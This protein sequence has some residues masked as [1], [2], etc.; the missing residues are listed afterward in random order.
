MSRTGL[1]LIDSGTSYDFAVGIDGDGKQL[2]SIEPKPWEPGDSAQ[3]FRV[4]L[5]PWDEGIASNRIDYDVTFNGK[6][7]QRPSRTY[8][9]ANADLSWPGIMV[10][11]PALGSIT[12]SGQ[13]SSFFYSTPAQ[14]SYV[15]VPDGTIHPGPTSG[16]GYVATPHASIHPTAGPYYA[17]VTGG[18]PIYKVI[19]S[20]NGHIYL[21]GGQFVY[22]VDRDYTA[23]LVKDFGTGKQVYDMEPFNNELIFAMGESVK[24][25][26]MDTAE[27]FTQ[28]SD[29]TFAIALGRVG[30]FLWR[31]ESVNKISNCTTTP[32]TLSN[33]TPAS[34]NQYS[35][36]D[37]TF[38]ITDIVEFA[39][40]PAILKPDGVYFPDANTDF[41]NQTP[42]L[43]YDSHPDNGKGAFTAW[44]YLW[45]PSAVGL[46]RVT[47]GESIPFGP[48]LTGMPNYRFWVRGGVEWAGDIYLLCNDQ[49]GLSNTSVFKMQAK[50]D[51]VVFHQ[52]VQESSTTL[53]Y[54][55][56][57]SS[58][59][60]LPSVLF[61]F[62]SAVS[63]FKLGRGGG[64]HID[65]PLYEWGTAL[66]WQSGDFVLGPDLALE[67]YLMG[68]SVVSD[69]DSSES[70]TCSYEIDRSGSFTSLLDTQDGSGTAPITNTSGFAV[71][72]RYATVSDKGQ[73]F[74]LKLEGT[75]DSGLGSDRLEVREVW[76]Y[77]FCHP[78][79]VDTFIVGIY[80][81]RQAKVR[82]IKQGRTSGETL[83]LFRKWQKDGTI[84]TC[85]LNDYEESRTIRVRVVGSKKDPVQTV[86]KA[87]ADEDNTDVVSVILR[88]TDFANT[89]AES[90]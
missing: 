63:Y 24:I 61:G 5:H 8:I 51:R 49:A 1:K 67:A 52:L 9:K 7:V 16:V 83:R 70:L 82:G 80:A 46:L 71:N 87:G 12:L 50:G 19:R 10:P 37:T 77:G 25:W 30:E 3:E 90:L 89:Y 13:G 72:H 53:G 85:Q 27:T 35:A 23:T 21:A 39:G 48:E 42:Q 45:I 79:L 66:E 31:A 4:P 75:Q 57:A 56:T 64:R 88:R 74:N 29:N 86:A 62:G 76:A 32:L 59:F 38:S 78:R 15:A 44:G 81:A 11:P 43:A 22:R 26:K 40:V 60:P 73:M 55:I 47:Q 28:A 69:C 41:H 68:V 6:L 2:L 14:L 34:P 84:L 65:D 33:W 36:G 17:A 18:E 58:I 20:F 54:F